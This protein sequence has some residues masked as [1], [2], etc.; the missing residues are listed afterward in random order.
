MHPLVAPDTDFLCALEKI[1]IRI[2][3]TSKQHL[4]TE[5]AVPLVAGRRCST[6]FTCR[7]ENCAGSVASRGW[8]GIWAEPEVKWHLSWGHEFLV[9]KTFPQTYQM[10]FTSHSTRQIPRTSGPRVTPARWRPCPILPAHT[11][12]GTRE[13]I[14]REDGRGERLRPS[15][16][17][18]RRQ[19]SW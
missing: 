1:N 2:I 18:P 12:P 15:S 10:A 13:E 5:K 16:A 4:S 7:L 17:L 14:C 6:Q 19:C 11:S 3:L 8:L 9:W